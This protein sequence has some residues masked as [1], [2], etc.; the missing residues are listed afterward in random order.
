VNACVD[1]VLSYSDVFLDYNKDSNLYLYLYSNFHHYFYFYFYEYLKVM[2]KLR[3]VF[4]INLLKLKQ[5]IEVYVIFNTVSI[6]I[7]HKF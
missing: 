1:R 2:M 4:I 7:I 3:N 6:L 5:T